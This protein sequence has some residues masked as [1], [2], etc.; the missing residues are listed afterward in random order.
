MQVFDINEE[1]A[2][3]MTNNELLVWISRHYE[4]RKANSY[5][6]EHILDGKSLGQIVMDLMDDKYPDCIALWYNQ[7]SQKVT[8]VFAD[9]E[10]G[11]Q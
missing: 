9:K 4:E 3:R 1:N 5:K 6:R 7:N 8:F 10:R 2:Y 11:G